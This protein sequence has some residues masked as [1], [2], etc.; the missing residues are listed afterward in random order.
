MPRSGTRSGRGGDAESWR[1]DDLPRLPP[2]QGLKKTFQRSK[3]KTILR[4]GQVA[5][6][7]LVQDFGLSRFFEERFNIALAIQGDRFAR[8][9]V[10]EAPIVDFFDVREVM[11]DRNVMLERVQLALAGPAFTSG[12]GH[13]NG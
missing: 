1:R 2:W 7:D 4:S 5:R 13:N 11:L 9:W 3:L 8:V 10:A 12:L 6:Y